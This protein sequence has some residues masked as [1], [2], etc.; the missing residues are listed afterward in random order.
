MH[1][2]CHLCYQTHCAR[3][4]NKVP[5]QRGYRSSQGGRQFAPV[6][7]VPVIVCVSSSIVRAPLPDRVCCQMS[8]LNVGLDME[9]SVD[10]GKERPELNP[11]VGTLVKGALR[12]PVFLFTQAFVQPLSVSQ[13]EI[14]CARSSRSQ[15]SISRHSPCLGDVIFLDLMKPMVNETGFAI[16]RVRFINGAS[17]SKD[18][19]HGW[20]RHCRSGILL[21]TPFHRFNSCQ[22]FLSEH[23][24]GSRQIGLV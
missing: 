3:L 9:A 21:C 15:H 5:G 4:A 2:H 22:V 8:R 12:S 14:V 23:G 1:Y 19:L 18:A 17:M 10:E 24:R 20:I 6:Q 11:V 16:V 7:P 13:P